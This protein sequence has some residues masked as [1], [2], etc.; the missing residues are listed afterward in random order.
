[1]LESVN[2]HWFKDGVAASGYV[3]FI[4]KKADEYGV[5]FL[6]D[7]PAYSII[8]DD[9]RVKGIY[10]KTKDGFIK[11]N[12]KATIFATGGVGHNAKLIAKQGCSVKNLKFLSLPSNTGDGYQITMSVGAKICW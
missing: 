1:M 2:S 12:A 6:L 4:K 7:S 5:K 11:I 3:P 9:Q 8:Y 10:A